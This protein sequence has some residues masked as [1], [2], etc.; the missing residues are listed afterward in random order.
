MIREANFAVRRERILR[1][2]LV[3]DDDPFRAFARCAALESRFHG[4][5]RAAAAAEALIQ[6][7]QPVFANKIALVI[8]GLNLD[9]GLAGPAFVAELTRRFPLM[10]ILALAREGETAQ[11]YPGTSVRFLA[12][13]ASPDEIVR[14]ASDV[15]SHARA[16]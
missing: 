9:G 1:S 4:V 5:A 15:L 14:A 10:P 16:A 8:A 2:I 13:N 6:L 11:D 3:V 7:D 12:A